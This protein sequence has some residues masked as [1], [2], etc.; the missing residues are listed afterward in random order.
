VQDYT[1]N[2][3][4]KER[5]MTTSTATETPPVL[6]D[7]E[8]ESVGAYEEIMAGDAG[9]GGVSDLEREIQAFFE[10]SEVTYQNEWAANTVGGYTFAD[11]D[12]DG[13]YDHLEITNQFGSRIYC[14][15]GIWQ[16]L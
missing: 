7:L 11:M 13:W 1:A 9:G 14:G 6:S 12:H 4:D 10:R 15:N 5:L 8:I 16:W 2:K 3:S